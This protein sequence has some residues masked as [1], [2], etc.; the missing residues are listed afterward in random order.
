[1]PAPGPVPP[2]PGLPEWDDP[3]EIVDLDAFGG[4]WSRLSD[5][6]D[7][8][9]IDW[10]IH[11]EVIGAW[12]QWTP[13]REMRRAAYELAGK[14][15][16]EPGPEDA[17]VASE[18]D[19]GGNF[20]RAMDEN[21]VVNAA[22]WLMAQLVA[23][24]RRGPD[25]TDMEDDEPKLVRAIALRTKDLEEEFFD[26][27]SPG[28]I[29]DIPLVATARNH[30]IGGKSAIE[31]FGNDVLIEF[32]A[33]TVGYTAGGWGPRYDYRD[34]E[35]SINKIIDIL[36][37]IEVNAESELSNEEIDED[38][39]GLYQ[40]EIDSVDEIK[41]LL[42]EY[43][44][45]DRRERDELEEKRKE[46]TQRLEDMAI[47]QASYPGYKSP[48]AQFSDG[49][50]L[51]WGGEPVNMD[52]DSDYYYEVEDDPEHP[53]RTTEVITG[54]RFEVVSVERGTESNPVDKPFVSKVRLRQVGV[55]DPTYPR[56]LVNIGGASEIVEV[57]ALYVF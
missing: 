56:K 22:K 16:E 7:P 32:E 26:R 53:S 43:D 54:G 50:P 19:P 51:R 29:V 17:A 23:A 31:D 11:E 45:I 27:M 24:G 47:V 41:Q 9:E 49:E 37:E 33:G 48:D 6:T 44:K 5:L 42:K 34:E 46:I 12:E 21:F 10:E 14:D 39:R 55:F 13:C 52:T 38:D 4:S 40:S 25:Q 30:D 36:D 8:S 3:S 18:I 20:A 57:K 2:P 28:E 1:M 35:S 15:P